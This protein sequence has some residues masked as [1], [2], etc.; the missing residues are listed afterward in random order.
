MAELRVQVL[1]RTTANRR[2]IALEFSTTAPD[3]EHGLRVRRAAPWAATAQVSPVPR[4]LVAA[5]AD[6]AAAARHRAHQADAAVRLCWAAGGK[7]R[8]CANSCHCQW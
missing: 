8:S 7:V 4:A 2:A 6:V 3:G 1:V 5:T